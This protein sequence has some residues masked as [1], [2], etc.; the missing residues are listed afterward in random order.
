M[1]RCVPRLLICE[2]QDKIHCQSHQYQISDVSA[3]VARPSFINTSDQRYVGVGSYDAG[4]EMDKR[5]MRS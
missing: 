2:H 1:G 4:L 3:K 5:A